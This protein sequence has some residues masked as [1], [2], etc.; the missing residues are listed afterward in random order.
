MCAEGWAE[1]EKAKA[2]RNP[3]AKREHGLILGRSPSRPLSTLTTGF[4]GPPETDLPGRPGRDSMRSRR[5][6]SRGPPGTQGEGTSLV[7]KPEQGLAPEDP[8]QFY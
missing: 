2:Q 3:G 5:G 8:F 6:M 7:S 1:A 4:S